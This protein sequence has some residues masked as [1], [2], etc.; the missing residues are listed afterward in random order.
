[1]MMKLLAHVFVNHEFLPLIQ[2][3]FI[4]QSV[5]GSDHCPVGVTVNVS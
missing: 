2:D 5:M 1:M 4:Q 3:G